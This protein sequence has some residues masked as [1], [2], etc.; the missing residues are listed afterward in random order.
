LLFYRFFLQRAG[1]PGEV[2][3]AAMYLASG[4]ASFTTGAILTIDGGASIP[5]SE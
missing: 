5:T 1:D 3:G 4:A 2:V